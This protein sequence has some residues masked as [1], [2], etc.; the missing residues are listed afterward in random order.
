MPKKIRRFFLRHLRK[1]RFLPSKFYVG[2][3]YEYF[4]GKKLDLY[5]PQD[6]NA[7]I[8]WYK[9]FFRPVILNQLVDKYHVRS[10]V[11]KKIGIEYL[12]EL[13]AVCNKA[14]DID[15]ESL[16]NSFV[17]KAN[18]T[19]GHNL[20]VENKDNLDKK[21]SVKLLN[22]WLGKNQYYRRGQEWA[23][24]DVKPKLIIEKFLKEK[25]K[26][27]LVD[28]KFY[29]FDGKVK[30]LDVHLDRESEHKQCCYDVD[31]NI[32]P[33]RKGKED[34]VEFFK[35]FKEPSN[36]KEMVKLSQILG[37]NLP[38]TRVDFYSI[39]GQSIFGELTF[40]PS[41]ARKK[42]YPEKYNKVI[43]DYFKLPKLK[44]Q[45]IITEIN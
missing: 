6:F 44:D 21:K 2:V 3:H 42:F 1:M 4:S 38:F 23:Y 10:F 5:N 45:K 39:N 9:V 20:I 17:I 16:P 27:T 7:K 12:N 37:E 35:D 40:Y 30:F 41:D 32:L 29:C 33:F 36:F 26:N 25:D 31:F 22:K 13:Y 8:E 18:H 19:N 15:F 11:E 43:G 28:Y 24:K 14:E 34:T